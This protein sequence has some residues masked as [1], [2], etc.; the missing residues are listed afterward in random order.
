M[1]IEY[2]AIQTFPSKSSK[3]GKIYTV[4][5]RLDTD[6]YTCDCPAW[7]YNKQERSCVHTL[8]VLKNYVDR[9]M[10]DNTIIFPI[11]RENDNI[12]FTETGEL[13]RKIMI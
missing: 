4:K 10:G 1:S 6:E 2:V 3:T 11:K 12:N 9:K 8:T 13:K 7:K 5:Q